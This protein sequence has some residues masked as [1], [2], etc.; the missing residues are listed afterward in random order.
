MPEGDTIFRTA[1]ALTRALVGK[2]IT[3]FRSNLPLV[4]RFHHDAPLTGRT[5]E[6]VE[7]HG[8]WLLIRFSGDA[9]LVTHM[10]MSG[11][12]HI[13][14][15]GER[16]QKP[17]HFMRIV[18]ENADFQAVAFRVP[19]AE[20]HTAASLARQPRIPRSSCDLLDPAFDAEA[21]A[22]RIALC[23]NEEI[24]DVLLHQYVLAGV[25]NEFKSEICFVCGIHP[26]IPVSALSSAQVATLV[27]ASH[28]LLHANVQEDSGDT[29]VT[30][31]GA[32]RRT[33]HASNAG[34]SVW[35]Y[36]RA[37]EP[38]RRCGKPI[39]QRKQGP[40]ARITFWCPQCQPW[41]VA[42]AGV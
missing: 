5:V 15:P 3:G 41:P 34:E 31:R 1:R 8:K 6:Q 11:E 24:A 20:M 30:Y 7:S 39:E 4:T 2:P 19:V 27:A 10:L 23:A 16:W 12:W 13:Y 25:G 18:L 22:A 35:V 17:G 36:G 26:F 21:A 29:I 33:T 38:C 42:L 14:R 40:D 28:R 32:H 37:G 9:I